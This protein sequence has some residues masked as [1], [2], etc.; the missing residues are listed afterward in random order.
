[1]FCLHMEQPY[2]NFNQNASNFKDEDNYVRKEPLTGCTGSGEEAHSSSSSS[3][4]VTVV[5]KQH[6]RALPPPSGLKCGSE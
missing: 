1:M 2:A 5:G 4:V 6:V 3:C